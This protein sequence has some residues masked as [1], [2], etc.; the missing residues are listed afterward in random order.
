[1]HNAAFAE[2]GLDWVYTAFRVGKKDLPEAV[3]AIRALDLAGLNVTMPHK[4]PVLDYLDEID[5]L[6]KEIKSVNTIVNTNGKLKGY[7]TDGE[8]FR[9]ALAEKDYMPKGKRVLIIGAGGAARAV[10]RN[11]AGNGA[12]AVD[13]ACRSVASGRNL[14]DIV[15][16]AGADSTTFDI[17]EN[18]K[19]SAGRADLIINATPLG[20]NSIDDIKFLVDGLTPGQFIADLS[21]VPPLS[22]FLVAAQERGCSVM[23]GL[24][25]LVHQGSLSY[26]LW[27]GREAPVTVMKRAVGE[28]S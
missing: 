13:V 9:R 23:G 12:S 3:A 19:E 21:T 6:A 16:A 5:S 15:K 10:A 27:T 24:S 22:A 14:A 20:K 8:G 26:E 17:S 28:K 18:A 4:E 2:Q 11:L 7:S 1:M 25:M